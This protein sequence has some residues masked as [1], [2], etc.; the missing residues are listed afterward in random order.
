MNIPNAIS[1]FRI[2]LVPVFMAAYSAGNLYWTLA[3]LLLCGASDIL[4]GA[5]ARKFNM[6]T[7]LGK[8]LDP[9]ADKLIQAAMMLCAAGR[10]PQM[11][12]LLTLHV[13]RELSL[14]ALGLYVKRTTGQIHSARWYG[15][16][17]TAFIYVL[18]LS[19]LLFPQ[20]PEMLAGIGMAL[21]GALMAFCM[22]MY[23]LDFIAILREYEHKKENGNTDR[24]S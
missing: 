8:V 21:C 6:V 22:V 19:L 3:V 18:M 1:L 5:I 10:M 4:D 23:T 9:V 17:C 16:L 13:L 7:Q 14:A 12:L 20:M 11:W 24:A 2:A 15:K